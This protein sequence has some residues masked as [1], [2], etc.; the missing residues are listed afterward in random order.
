MKN[1]SRT[2]HSTFLSIFLLILLACIP[3]GI[4]LLYEQDLDND[5]AVW[6][7]DDIVQACVVKKI[8]NSNSAS[9][10]VPPMVFAYGWNKRYILAKQYSQKSPFDV[11]TTKAN[12]FI[13]DMK[14]DKVYGP[15]TESE[16]L[17]TREMLGVPAKIDFTV[18]LEI[19]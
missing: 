1:C 13:V 14:N 12:W 15:M 4:G 3:G 6:A 11:D 9:C 19:K 8:E 10:K 17:E 16:Y 7:A 18:E 2:G 5:Y